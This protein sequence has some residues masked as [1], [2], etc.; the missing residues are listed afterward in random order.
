MDRDL[1]NLILWLFVGSKGGPTRARILFLIRESPMNVHRIATE[2]NLNY[3][4]VKYHLE[5][6]REHGIIERVGNDY[7]AIYVPSEVVEKNW[8]EIESI[9]RRNGL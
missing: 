4:T 1:R 9:L 3:R 6:M 2:L 5:L 8:G 7:G